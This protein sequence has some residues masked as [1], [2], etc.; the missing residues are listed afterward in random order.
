M[1]K[2]LKGRECG[3]GLSQR[4]DGRYSARFVSKSGKR[5]E[6]YFSK[7]AEAKK[8]LADTQYEDRHKELGTT[9]DMKVDAWFNYW[10]ENII[11]DLAPNTRRNYQERYD[12]NI[13]PFI[14]NMCIS[15][16]RPMHCKNVLNKMEEKYAGST[17]KQTYITMGTMFKSAVRNDIIEKHPM[18]N[19]YTKKP[20]KKASDHRVLTVEEQKRFLQV[21]KK[22]HNYRQYALILETG[23]RTGELIGLTWDAVDFEKRTLT[24]NKTLEYRYTNQCWRAGCTKTPNSYRT[25][26][27]T[28]NAYNIL[29]ELYE[30]RDKQKRS[31]ELSQKLP[32][33]DRRSGKQEFLNMEDLVFINFR[34]GLPTKNSSYD[35]HLYKLCDRAGL[36]HFSMHTLRHTFATRAIEQGVSPKVLQKFLGHEKITTTMDTYVHVTDDSMLSAIKQLENNNIG[37]D[38]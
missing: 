34:T 35:S 11:K 12:K 7:L 38:I 16:V 8:W 17:I 28:N 18:D 2:D 23:L 20:I 31:I 5:L 1:G 13:K 30:I 24:V 36:E 21:A 27:L 26:P 22:T 15:D 33:L 37:V 19:V 14:G 9:S 6:K 25:I 10:Q 32:Y 29:K 3:K 4:S